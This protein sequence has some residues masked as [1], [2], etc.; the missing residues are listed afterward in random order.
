MLKCGE[1]RDATALFEAHHPFTNRK[2]LETLLSRYEVD[3]TEVECALLDPADKTPDYDWPEYESKS[4]SD[5][6]A[7]V[8][9]FV[10]IFPAHLPVYSSKV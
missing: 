1:C 7:P 2:Y 5:V 6:Q 4:A 9:D 3:P 8:S 10:S